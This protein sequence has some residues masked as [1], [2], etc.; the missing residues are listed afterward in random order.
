MLFFLMLRNGRQLNSA[1]QAVV[2]HGCPAYEG[3]GLL[4]F[5]ILNLLKEGNHAFFETVENRM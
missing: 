4:M 3:F 5:Q 1:I 2:K